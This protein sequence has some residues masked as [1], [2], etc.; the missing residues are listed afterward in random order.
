ML[1][2]GVMA[3]SA[4][5]P[6]FA[7]PTAPT[8]ATITMDG[9]AKQYKA[10]RLLD[11]TTALK[12]GHVDHEG[13]HDVNDC[14]NYSY[15]L[16]EKYKSVLDAVHTM[17]DLN[18]DG[19]IDDRD[20]VKYINDLA[21]DPQNV[22]DFADKVF[23]QISAGNIAE[24]ATDS[25]KVFSGISQGYYL[26]AETQTDGD[27][28]T[29][30]LVMLDTHGQDNLTVKSK[31]GVPTLKKEVEEVND[32]TGENG[33]WGKGADHDIGDEVNFRLTG[34]MPENLAGYTKYKY[35][36]HDQLSQGLSFV[37]GSVSVTIDGKTVP[38]DQYTVT[39]PATDCS[40]EVAFSDIIATAKGMEGVN[41]TKDSEVIVYY[42]SLLTENA[43]TSYTGNKNDA[44]LEF[45]NDPY[46]KGD[47][48]PPTGE[49]PKDTN[50]TF[51]Y[52][53]I[54]NKV[55]ENKNPLAGAN[56]E[57]Q[58]F[59]KE[60]NDFVT[61]KTIDLQN[62]QT[63]F[64]FIGLDEGKYKLV[65]TKIPDGYNKADD[66]EFEVVSDYG[67]NEEGQMILKDL[68]VKRGEEVISAGEN[69]EFATE[70]ADGKVATSIVN[71]PGTR[72]P[73]TG[74]AGTFLL[75]GA[76]VVLLAAGGSMYV[77][78]KRKLD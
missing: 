29:I 3:V 26:I 50:V 10:Y 21:S 57:L 22:R 6:A 1:L 48:E 41:L 14:Y 70:V 37:K 30:S 72:L 18:G 63:Q 62:G 23:A 11:L 36:F 46:Y 71:I 38:A 49:T 75:Y 65:E 69:P 5:A 35:V 34:T 44:Y 16:N 73:S 12:A 68:I 66:V 17:T 9:N 67:E 76:G 45:S 27:Y 74:G 43:T 15:T 42:K 55:D 47:G 58:K 78:K 19:T 51:T 77:L 61:I 39:D 7:A 59:I 4:M 20:Y 64:D 13:A 53:L 24:D 60:E 54:V 8:S 56:F 33:T 40:F 2:S 52:K 31:E 28:D 25:N 32:S